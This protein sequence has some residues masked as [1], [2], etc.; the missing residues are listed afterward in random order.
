MT[1]ETRSRHLIGS[2]DWTLLT[3]VTLLLLVG[4]VMVFSASYTVGLNGYDDP[5]FFF[6]KQLMWLGLGI[7][8]MVATMR[9]P[10]TVWERF[11]LIIGGLVILALVG[12]VLL[13]N[14][15]F[16]ASRSY[17]SGSIRP[18][19]AAK[20]A[21]VLYVAT[22]LTSKGE[23]IRSVSLGLVPFGVIIGILAVLLVLQREL[24]TAVLIVTTATIMLFIAG[25]EVKQLLVAAVIIAATFFLIVQSNDYANARVA[26][27]WASLGNPLASEEQQ[28]AQAVQ[29]LLRGGVFGMGVG[30][31]LA[32][33][34]G[35]LPVAW[36]D[37]I[38]GVIGEEFGLVGTL[39]IV[40]LFALLAYRGLRIALRAPDNFSML[41]A[42]GITAI[43]VLEALL[44]LGVI[45]AMVPPTG[46][47]LPFI[48]YGGS[49]LV[50]AMAG[51]GILL[52]ISRYS[53][54]KGGRTTEAGRYSY[55]RFD[56]GGR[57]GG[58]RLPRTGRSG[59]ART[60][61]FRSTTPRNN[62]R[63]SVSH[64]RI[65]ERS[66]GGRSG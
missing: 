13:G 66:G 26:S 59:T 6:F 39:G 53:H 27:Y 18:S 29:A 34:R 28:V 58:T 16:G 57:D 9:I 24:S 36:S 5:F 63:D 35:L 30:N 19:E 47:N 44:N 61:A 37:S 38:F 7:A 11:S 62:L 64:G 23:R 3:V 25:S 56:I 32:Q 41:T 42:T 17:V 12:V 8:A 15:I 40:L 50:S 54:A 20:V 22:W 55:A 45:V 51:V 31:G 10:Y 43:F 60:S 65:R 46:V 2:Y 33:T 14:E 21:I 1:A 52:N 4:L 48:S 49:A